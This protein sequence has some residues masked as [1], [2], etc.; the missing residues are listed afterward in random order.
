MNFTAN[1]LPR[2]QF[3]IRDLDDIRVKGKNEPVKVFELL[4]PDQWRS[5]SML[6]EFVGEFEAGRELIASA[7]GTVLKNTSWLVLH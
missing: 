3:F 1:Q 5:E 6:R 4:R 2:D 7:P